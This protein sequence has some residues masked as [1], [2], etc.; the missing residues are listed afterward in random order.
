MMELVRFIMFVLIG[1][2]S[3]YGLL[4]RNGLTLGS[5]GRMLKDLGLCL[6]IK[7]GCRMF[8]AFYH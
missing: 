4:L 5:L 6:K 7:V 3:K 2:I 1:L 8:I